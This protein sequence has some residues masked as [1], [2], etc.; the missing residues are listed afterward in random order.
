VLPRLGRRCFLASLRQ[1]IRSAGRWRWSVELDRP[2]R[3]DPASAVTETWCVET[4]GPGYPLVRP[5]DSRAGMVGMRYVLSGPWGSE[6]DRGPPGRSAEGGDGRAGM[7]APRRARD[8]PPPGPAGARRPSDPAHRRVTGTRRRQARE[9]PG[10]GTG[11][12]AR[13]VPP[14]DAAIRDSG[15]PPDPAQPSPS[16]GM[17]DPRF[18]PGPDTAAGGAR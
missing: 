17:L 12:R 15:E 18:E 7:G 2:G 8:E 13:G 10:P 11:V 9:D 1:R 3:A 6:A 5:V 16:S 4:P 14:V